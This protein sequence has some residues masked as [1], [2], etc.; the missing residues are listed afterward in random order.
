MRGKIK[1]L[2]CVIIEYLSFY[3]LATSSANHSLNLHQIKFNRSKHLFSLLIYLMFPSIAIISP[4]Q[5]PTGLWKGDKFCVA[6]YYADNLFWC[7]MFRNCFKCRDVI[8]DQ[9]VCTMSNCKPSY[10]QFSPLG[11]V[12]IMISIVFTTIYHFQ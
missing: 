1:F 8:L 3:T 9:G 4:T 12:K 11:F 10:L 2:P 5:C 6:F 7:R